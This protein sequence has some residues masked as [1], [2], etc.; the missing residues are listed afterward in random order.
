MEELIWASSGQT[1]QRIHIVDN[2]IFL[3]LG[4][5]C[6][7]PINAFRPIIAPIPSK[8]TGRQT[9]AVFPWTRSFPQPDP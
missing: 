1:L 3:R 4:L 6:F 9:E 2:Q 7:V 5:P 8:L